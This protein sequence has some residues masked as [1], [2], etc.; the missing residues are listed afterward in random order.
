MIRMLL[1]STATLTF[2]CGFNDLQPV[3]GSIGCRCIDP[4]TLGVKHFCHDSHRAAAD[5]A[6]CYPV[7]YRAYRAVTRPGRRSM[8][9][10]GGMHLR[11]WYYYSIS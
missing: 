7:I 8:D 6:G 11:K 4:A 1:L 5:T 10:M 2:V 9:C 3:N